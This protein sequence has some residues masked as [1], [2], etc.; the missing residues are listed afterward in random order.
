MD[1]LYAKLGVDQFT[2]GDA[3]PKIRAF[4]SLL[5]VCLSP[6]AWPILVW[7]TLYRGRPAATFGTL[8]KYGIC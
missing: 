7:I 8:T 2:H 1:L 3:R 6:W 5:F 4:V